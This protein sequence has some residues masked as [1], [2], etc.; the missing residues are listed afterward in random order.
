[1]SQVKSPE[2]FAATCSCICLC[3]CSG[4]CGG[5]PCP[6]C[7]NVP[8]AKRADTSTNAIEQQEKSGSK[9]ARTAPINLISRGRPG[10]RDADRLRAMAPKVS[11]LAPGYAPASDAAP[12]ASVKAFR[13]ALSG[14]ENLAVALCCIVRPPRKNCGMAFCNVFFPAAAFEKRGSACRTGVEPS[15]DRWGSSMGPGFR[16]PRRRRELVIRERP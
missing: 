7:A 9:K 8:T 1:M 11:I 4:V 5:G 12:F 15:A 14:D 16:P 2:G 6:F 13:V 3:N 10:S